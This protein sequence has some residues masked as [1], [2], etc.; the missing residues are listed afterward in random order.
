MDETERALGKASLSW[1]LS[2]PP[3]REKRQFSPDLLPALWLQMRALPDPSRHRHGLCCLSHHPPPTPPRENISPFPIPILQQTSYIV[4][5]PESWEEG[6]EEKTT[7]NG[8]AVLPAFQGKGPP[9]CSE[10]AIHICLQYLPGVLLW[11]PKDT[12]LQ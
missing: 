5:P 1:T 6:Q 12:I 7:S 2:Y 10:S 8:V 4:H 9:G 3:W 11:A